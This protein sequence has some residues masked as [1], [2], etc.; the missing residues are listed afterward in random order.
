MATGTSIAAMCA[1]SSTASPSTR[2]PASSI[3]R[4]RSSLADQIWGQLTGAPNLFGAVIRDP[5]GAARPWVQGASAAD[6]A[7]N[8]PWPG[9]APHGYNCV[10]DCGDA[11]YIQA[12]LGDWTNLDV[13]KQIDL[14]CDVNGDLLIDAADVHAGQWLGRPVRRRPAAVMRTAMGVINFADINPFVAVLSGGTPCAFDN[15]D[16]NGDGAV[17]FADIN[18]FVTAL[19]SGATCP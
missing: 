17:N 4:R 2:R 11:T 19:S 16:V 7:G 9:A 15:A 12:N 1:T 10:V 3:A 18:P 6:V 13:A 8:T 5:N 14:S